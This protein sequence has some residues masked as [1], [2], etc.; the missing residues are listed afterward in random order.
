[1]EDQKMKGKVPFYTKQAIAH[2][3]RLDEMVA[4]LYTESNF[5]MNEIA[6]GLSNVIRDY[7]RENP[8]YA[9]A[10]KFIDEV[11]N[12]AIRRRAA[13]EEAVRE[14]YERIRPGEEVSDG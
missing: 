6:E 2:L 1:M 10:R 12:P 14:E 3:L 9:E 7:C 8:Q 4:E 13:H 5:N 11:V